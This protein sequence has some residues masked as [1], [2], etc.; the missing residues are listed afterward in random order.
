M[1]TATSTILLLLLLASS[2]LAQDNALVDVLTP[3]GRGMGFAVHKTDEKVV[4]KGQEFYV[5]Y[6]MTAKHVVPD[7]NGQIMVKWPIMK[8]GKYLMTQASIVVENVHA[9]VAVL[10]TIIPVSCKPFKIAK[11]FDEFEEVDFDLQ[12]GDKKG[13]ISESS[14]KWRLNISVCGQP[15]D[16][17][18]PGLNEKKEV[19]AM[20]LAGLRGNYQSSEGEILWP[21]YCASCHTL[22][23]YLQEA[24][25]S[26]N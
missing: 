24:I 9:D 16:S 21:I 15:G 18:S 13:P 25:E 11:S 1:K 20:L 17:G 12:R 4:S 8:E 19:V 23:K 22:N 6:V 5:G 10:E 7:P 14:S 3:D 2:A 26:T